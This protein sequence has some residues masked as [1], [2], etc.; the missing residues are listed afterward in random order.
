MGSRSNLPAIPPPLDVNAVRDTYVGQGYLTTDQFR[1]LEEGTARIN[2]LGLGDFRWHIPFLARDVHGNIP[3]STHLQAWA[4]GL[5]QPYQGIEDFY[6]RAIEAGV[7]PP[8]ILNDT[9]VHS[10]PA[11]STKFQIGRLMIRLGLVVLADLERALGIQQLIKLETGLPTRVG[12]ILS[13]ITPMSVIDATRTLALHKGLPYVSLDQTLPVIEH[14]V[15]R[16]E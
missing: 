4:S 3:W 11:D 10:P 6:R 1:V 8:Y 15:P 9:H 16:T 12:R 2:A 14:T 7:L 13:A 5:R